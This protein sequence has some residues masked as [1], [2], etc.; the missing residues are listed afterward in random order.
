[1]VAGITVGV[2]ITIIIG[3]GIDRGDG[4]DARGA[5]LC[6]LIF[7]QSC[8]DRRPA[9]RPR[10]GEID[11]EKFERTRRVGTAPVDISGT[12][13]VAT[14]RRPFHETL[15]LSSSSWFRCGLTLAPTALPR[16][17]LKSAVPAGIDLPIGDLMRPAR[18]DGR[19]SSKNI[20][21]ETQPSG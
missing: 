16:R 8:L 4:P 3:I 18:L 5:H 19:E 14:H 17:I 10:C 11:S 7:D 12:S 15:G 1:M 9:Y 2:G 20:S 21:S 13:V 6:G